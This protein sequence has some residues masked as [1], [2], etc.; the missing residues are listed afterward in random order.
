MDKIDLIIELAKVSHKLISDLPKEDR[1]LI[2]K[3]ITEV[4]F[5]YLDLSKENT[6]IY[7]KLIGTLV[8]NAD[9]KHL[10]AGIE[11][12][13]KASNQ[14][15]EKISPESIVQIFLGDTKKL[16][17]DLGI[18]QEKVKEGQTCIADAFAKSIQEHSKELG[19]PLNIHTLTALL[20]HKTPLSLVDQNGN[21]NQQNLATV[22]N[23][24]ATNLLDH[25]RSHEEHQFRYEAKQKREMQ[26]QQMVRE[27]A[28]KTINQT[29]MGLFRGP[30][31]R[32]QARAH[33]IANNWTPNYHV[34]GL[35]MR[36]VTNGMNTGYQQTQGRANTEMRQKVFEETKS[37]LNQSLSIL[38]PADRSNLKS[39]SKILASS[40]DQSYSAEIR[41]G[42]LNQLNNLGVVAKSFLNA[43]TNMDTDPTRISNYYRKE[44]KDGKT[45]DVF[46]DAQTN[47]TFYRQTGIDGKVEFAKSTENG[48]Y[49]FVKKEDYSGVIT[50][51]AIYEDRL[52][53]VAI[54]P[55]ELPA[56]EKVAQHKNSTKTD[57]EALTIRTHKASQILKPSSKEISEISDTSE[58]QLKY[59]T[60]PKNP[61]VKID[62]NN[63]RVYRYTEYNGSTSYAMIPKNGSAITRSI[64]NHKMQDYILTDV[65]KKIGS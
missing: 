61:S 63:Y 39:I 24:V 45:Y 46:I 11:L 4:A 60:D 16:S 18:S 56:T 31:L 5:D 52:E 15:S 44:G 22:A 35:I 25:P 38:S 14:Y 40:S 32:R 41:V 30:H 65:L 57:K 9:P 48:K 43:N 13:I 51:L 49:I 37:R 2:V 20:N 59:S 23:T 7:A 47:S 6:K 12:A 19:K 58:L 21:Y 33:N 10:D 29:R 17:K 42:D 36:H 55:I 64:R 34:G 27:E 53:K 1:V 62:F 3:K 26:H 8:S 54:K 50:S 28:H